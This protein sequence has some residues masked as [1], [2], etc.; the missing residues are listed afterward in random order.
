[1][2]RPVSP[3]DSRSGHLGR[4]S[5]DPKMD[6]VFKMVFAAEKNRHLLILC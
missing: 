4:F 1:M 3:D 6:V 5:L 2:T